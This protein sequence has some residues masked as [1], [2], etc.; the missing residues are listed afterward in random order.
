VSAGFRAAGTLIGNYDGNGSPGT[1]ALVQA[2][3][4][5]TSSATFTIFE[6]NWIHRSNPRM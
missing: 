5:V 6:E 4:L 2:S 3:N 1:N